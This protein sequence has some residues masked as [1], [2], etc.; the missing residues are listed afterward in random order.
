MVQ[1]RLETEEHLL[2]MNAYKFKDEEKSVLRYSQKSC[3]V[4][5][6]VYVAFDIDIHAR[7][8]AVKREIP[9]SGNARISSCFTP[10]PMESLYISRVF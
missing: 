9:I 3:G 4:V 5:L 2:D 6:R 8:L 7:C 1:N 10:T